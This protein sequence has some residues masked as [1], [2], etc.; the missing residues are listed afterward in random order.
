MYQYANMVIELLYDGQLNNNLPAGKLHLDF[1][2]QTLCH[3]LHDSD[4]QL[5]VGA[6]Y[7]WSKN[8]KESSVQVQFFFLSGCPGSVFFL[9]FLLSKMSSSITSRACVPL[10]VSA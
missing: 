10:Y 3:G 2:L 8:T 9:N 7:L 6:T 4:I 5:T 1:E